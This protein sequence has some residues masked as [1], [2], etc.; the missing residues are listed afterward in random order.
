MQHYSDA[1]H[2][3]VGTGEDLSI[4]D[5]ADMVRRIVHPAATIVYDRSKPDG[6]P[7]K[8]LDVSRLHA[9]GWRHRTSLGEGIEQ[10]LQLVP[11]QSCRRPRN[12]GGLMCLPPTSRRWTNG[13]RI[14]RYALDSTW[15]APSP[16]C[17]S[18]CRREA[19]E[20]FGEEVLRKAAD[21][22]K[23]AAGGSAPSR[24]T[25]DRT[26]DASPDDDD[27]SGDGGTA[28]HRP[29]ADAA[30]GSRQ[31]DRELLDDAARARAGHHRAHREDRRVRGNGRSSS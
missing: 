3:N 23:P 25:T 16:T 6:T 22:T 2:I 5:L 12:L 31:E 7:R 15:T 13:D 19:V 1:M 20:L 17:T 29:A 30:V 10:H 26:R 11:G 21:D 4:A 8:L 14:C 28:S 18:R 24:V 9:L 27:T